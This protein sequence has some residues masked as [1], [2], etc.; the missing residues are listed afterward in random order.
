MAAA[1][2]GFYSVDMRW[3]ASIDDAGYVAG[4]VASALLFG[5]VFTSTPWGTAADKIG[6]KRA[7]VLSMLSLSVGN[8]AWGFAT[9]LWAAVACRFVFMGALSGWATVMVPVCLDVG[10]EQHQ[11]HVFAQVLGAGTAMGALSPSIGAM[12]YGELDPNHPALAPGV[13]G[14]ALGATAAL[15][16]QIWLTDS[17]SNA[18][19]SGSDDSAAVPTKCSGQLTVYQAI[20]V[21]PLPLITFLRGMN[22]WCFFAVMESNPLF[23]IGSVSAGG[24]GM[25]KFD[26]GI[27][28]GCAVCCMFVF[29][30]FAQGTLVNKLGMRRCVYLGGLVSGCAMAILPLAGYWPRLQLLFITIVL[31]VHFAAIG[32][33][34][35]GAVGLSNVAVAEHSEIKGTLNGLVSTFEALAKAMGPATA[36][37]LIALALSTHNTRLFYCGM[38]VF[39]AAVHAVGWFLPLPAEQIV[40]SSAAT[41]EENDECECAVSVLEEGTEL[42]QLKGEVAVN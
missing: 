7:I 1:Y 21:H 12:M 35:S 31:S 11:A 33:A 40:D 23:F 38:G 30:T 27:A 41:L 14:A 26:V 18:S 15:A 20:R 36:S 28:L 17:S 22:G 5:R 34:Q 8:L 16:A 39:I 3:T 37:P 6:S 29:S 42:S 2:I 13:T 4:W 32:V 9:P 19:T 10:G 24:L 25:S